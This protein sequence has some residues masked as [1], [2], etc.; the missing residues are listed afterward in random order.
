MTCLFRSFVF[1]STEKL[2][3]SILKWERKISCVCICTY[4]N[5]TFQ[6]I[7][8][9]YRWSASYILYN[10]Y[11]RLFP[12]N[13]KKKKSGKF[14]IPF[15]N[16]K[17]RVNSIQRIIYIYKYAICIYSY[18]YNIHMHV[19]SSIYM[20]MSYVYIKSMLGKD[21]KSFHVIDAAYI[22]FCSHAVYIIYSY[23]YVCAHVVKFEGWGLGL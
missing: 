15:W 19:F 20:Y 3:I 22:S 12:I 1:C 13:L 7:Q 16:I 23:K 8:N 9:W 4:L 5:Q 11:V 17:Y 21:D 10:M 2:Y 6:V 14:I 18:I